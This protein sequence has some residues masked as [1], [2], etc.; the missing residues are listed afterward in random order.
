MDRAKCTVSLDTL[1]LL[2]K[3]SIESFD[4]GAYNS[5]DQE[6]VV[7]EYC[8]FLQSVAAHTSR[9]NQK[10]LQVAV[11]DVFGLSDFVSKKIAEA[12][13]AALSYAYHKGAKATSG[14]KLSDSV[15]T[16]LANFRTASS[17]VS[18]FQESIGARVSTGSS[19]S[20]LAIDDEQPSSTG[21]KRTAEDIYNMY[22]VAPPKAKACKVSGPVM[23]VS[24]QE[25]LSSQ[26]APAAPK[27]LHWSKTLPKIFLL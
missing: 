22:N 18:R 17:S 1:K 27:V 6:V 7:K 13:A 21:T 4:N 15:K 24:S 20:M 5:D 16:I 26:E 11:K 2:L 12:L 19:S 25:V 14:K 10:T 8:S 9:L 23:L 3:G